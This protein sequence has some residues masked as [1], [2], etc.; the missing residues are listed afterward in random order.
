MIALKLALLEFMR[1]GTRRAPGGRDFLWLSLLAFFLQLL[2]MLIL[3][4]REGV[5]ERSVDAFLGN[6]DGYG[7]P[8][9]TVPNMLGTAQ[10]VM[11]SDALIDE[12]RGAGF[13]AAPFRRLNN[14]QMIRMPGREVWRT[15]RRGQ[16]SDFSGMAAD[17]GGPIFPQKTLVPTGGAVP[18]ALTGAWDIVLDANIFG[19][20]FDLAA[21]RESLEG[22]L[23]QAYLDTIPADAAQLTD[24]SV[25]W[26]HVKTRRDEV[27]TPFKVNWA[28]H[29]GI[30]STSTAFIV[31]IEMYN[32][33]EMAKNSSRLCVF[34]E[35]GPSFPG[36]VQALRSDR[37]FTMTA[38]ERLAFTA[39]ME[40]LRDG[41]GG[42]L[43]STGSRIRL[44][45]EQPQNGVSKCEQGAPRDLVSLFL[46]SANMDLAEDQIQMIKTTDFL[47]ATPS[48]LEAACS[49][50]SAELLERA[51]QTDRN[52]ECVGSIPVADFETGYADMLVYANSRASLKPLVQ[53]LSCRPEASTDSTGP[54]GATPAT[55][56]QLCVPPSA[57]SPIFES[58]LNLH[59]IYKDS[60]NRFSFLTGLLQAVTVPVGSA[61]LFVL[62]AI[63]WV[64]LGTILGHRR[65]RYAMLLSNGLSWFQV[66]FMIVFQGM[67][68]VTVAMVGSVALLF[69]AKA[70]MWVRMAQVTK[71][72]ESITL[73]ETIDVLPVNIAIIGIVYLATLLVTVLLTVLQTR[74]NGIRPSSPLEKLLH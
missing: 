2:A 36:R 23:P 65:V 68:A 44:V 49:A 56:K 19:R 30:G 52:G 35:G 16:Q 14:G 28:Q 7:I 48:H 39:K 32:L 72:Y 31:P 71:E 26:L 67:L 37:I 58:R 18:P 38:E 54:A 25:I 34:L 53:F 74:L 17:F 12:M 27:L 62:V 59:E 24:M 20:L 8:V 41:I 45:F 6:R 21:Y 55:S 64:Q 13:Y 50:L 47:S 33:Y 11:V 61:M 42:E 1:A 9:W 66:N 70:G 3:S 40:I 63:L 43:I 4:A 51:D 5:L 73:G 15:E 29:F 46:S 57:K 22:R 69:V 10:P 60:L